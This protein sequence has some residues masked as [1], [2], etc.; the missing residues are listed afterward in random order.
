MTVMT[1]ECKMFEK[2]VVQPELKLL[3][4]SILKIKSMSETDHSARL[5]KTMEMARNRLQ[6]VGFDH[7][8]RWV[9]IQKLPLLH[10][11]IQKIRKGDVK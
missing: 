8:V 5:L 2:D 1:R 10:V 6:D 9:I 7:R 4:N 11:Q 3:Q